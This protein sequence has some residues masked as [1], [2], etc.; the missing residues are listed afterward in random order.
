MKCTA[1]NLRRFARFAGWIG[2]FIFLVVVTG[3]AGDDAVRDASTCSDAELEYFLFLAEESRLSYLDDQEGVTMMTNGLAALV[4][5]HGEDDVVIAF[6]GSIIGDRQKRHPFSSLGGAA[7][8]QT[9][10]DWVTTNLKGATGF[11]PRQYT[12]AAEFVARQATDLPVTTTIHLTGHSKGGAAAEYALV[13][14]LINPDLTAEQKDRINCTTFN[15]AVVQAGTWERLFRRHRRA[16][17]G[18][19]REA[20]LH[21]GRM[22]A[23]VMEDDPVSGLGAGETPRHGRR[24]VV[25]AT[26]GQGALAQHGIETVI[27]EL[28]A[29][30]QNRL[31]GGESIPEP[32]P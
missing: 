23:V 31:H 14:A 29:L 1:P 30:L 32:L 3:Y 10:R 6:R 2:V 8:R 17:A 24:V 25:P 28:T 16:D 4:T 15:G 9:Y 5:H 13:A 7:I 18:A 12:E 20:L 21:P 27:T 11:L 26:G 22:T 19:M